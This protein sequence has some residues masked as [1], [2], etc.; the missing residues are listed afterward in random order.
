MFAKV[1]DGK[2]TKFS[3]TKDEDGYVEVDDEILDN[4]AYRL[5]L[6]NLKQFKEEWRK[7]MEAEK[8]YV[9]GTNTNS[10]GKVKDDLELAGKPLPVSALNDV[11][12]WFQTSLEM[13]TYNPDANLIKYIAKE[14]GDE[15]FKVFTD[16]V[17]GLVEHIVENNEV[18]IPEIISTDYEDHVS[19]REL[20]ELLGDY[21]D[22]NFDSEQSFS[23]VLA[24]YLW[25]ARIDYYADE[26]EQAVYEKAAAMIEDKC[27]SD[28]EEENVLHD[29]LKYALDMMKDYGEID[30]ITRG[31]IKI[32]EK[33][34]IGEYDLTMFLSTPAEA[35][36]DFGSTHYYYHSTENIREE[37]VE[38]LGDTALSYLIHQQ[39]YKTADIF[40]AFQDKK[41]FDAAGKFIRSTTEEVENMTYTMSS[42]VVLAKLNKSNL[43][44]FADALK[45]KEGFIRID[46][47]QGA[48]LGLFDRW[49]GSG[50]L[51][52][53]E[54]EKDFVFP[55]EMI[56]DTFIE[57]A[58][59]DSAYEY[60]VKGVYDI[61]SSNW[62]DCM[63][64]SE[65]ET[66]RL[67]KE[68]YK[69]TTRR[70]VRAEENKKKDDY[71]R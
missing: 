22:G 23:D 19:K 29:M 1:E 13:I 63:S 2:I 48:E 34:F 67:I 51:I 31:Y 32:D 18:D 44:E 37:D 20:L 5:Q 50:S 10:F 71:E 68:D 15:G 3:F 61:G 41:K 30:E 16:Y 42:L 9:F 40:D 46:K 39:G 36:L 33:S 58:K 66:V 17:K 35:N 69:K 21:K 64:I 56:Q 43:Y 6:K 28:F 25:Y 45:N 54:L 7:F 27:M 65:D 70:A 49:D 62:K 38:E 24:D 60:S 8:E 55:V 53:I 52:G 47:K 12:D 59:R 4:A 11:V 14:F 26:F 57:G